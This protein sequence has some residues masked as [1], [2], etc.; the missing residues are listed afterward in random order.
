MC[1]SCP[2]THHV[3][4][5]GLRLTALHLTAWTK[6]ALTIHDT[7]VPVVGFKKRSHCAVLTGIGSQIFT[8]FSQG[9][10]FRNVVFLH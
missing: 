7:W 5:A 9:V 2:G 4:Q 3:G 1:V 10:G 8:C 6:G